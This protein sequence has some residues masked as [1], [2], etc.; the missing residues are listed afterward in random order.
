MRLGHDAMYRQQDMAVD[1]A[2]EFLRAL[3][4]SLTFSTEDIVEGVTAF[5]EKREPQWKGKMR[6]DQRF[7]LVDRPGRT[8]ALWNRDWSKD[9]SEPA[10]PDRVLVAIGAGFR[11]AGRAAVA[12]KFA[13][14]SPDRR[15]LISFGAGSDGRLAA[16]L[17]NCATTG[18]DLEVR[19]VR[20]FSPPLRW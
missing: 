9:Y 10:V 6:I 2:L 17:E 11:P 20:L 16:G 19:G 18:F 8:A 14:S 13:F 1:D 3:Q 4:L 5:F 12:F 7:E 15:R